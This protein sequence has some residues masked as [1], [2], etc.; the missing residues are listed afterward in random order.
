MSEASDWLARTAA[1]EAGT[2]AEQLASRLVQ[3]GEEAALLALQ[4][5][6]ADPAQREAAAA[7]GPMLQ[8]LLQA[9]R[10]APPAARRVATVSVSLGVRLF[11]LALGEVRR[12]LDSTR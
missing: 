1:R 10:S 6:A 5:A 4:R 9:S 12:A 8:A 2:L 3:R 11:S 7:A